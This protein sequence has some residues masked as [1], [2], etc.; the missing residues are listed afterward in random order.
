MSN[1]ENTVSSNKSKRS[2]L[3]KQVSKFMNRY[4]S[5]S[6]MHSVRIKG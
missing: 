2:R 6:N 5:N 1:F 3:L 4:K